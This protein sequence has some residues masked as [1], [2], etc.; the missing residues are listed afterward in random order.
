MILIICENNRTAKTVALAMG[1]KTENATGI[2][3][4][5]TITVATVPV[6][7][8]RQIP[9][10]EMTVEYP[11]I[12]EKF[13]MA[14]TMKQL[15]RKLKP[16][17]HDA[18]EVVFASDGGADAQARFFNICRHFRVG[19]PRS[20]M[21][22]SR[23]SYG[24]IRGAFHFRETGR[25]LHRLAQTGLVSKGMDI[26]FSYNIT[27]ALSNS[28][29]AGFRLSR[30][31][32]MA[33][34]YLA[35][36]TN[37]ANESD[38]PRS[39][40]S[41]QLNVNSQD[42]YE[43]TSIWEDQKEAEAV[44]AD[45]P[46]GSSV[47]GK[48]TITETTAYNLRFHTLLT[49]Q[50]DAYNNLG[51]LPDQT[52]RVA[53]SLY[54]KG[55]I[56]SPMTACS[57]LPANLRGHLETVFGETNGYPWGD[58][59]A[60]LDNHAIIT[61]R[62]TE[63]GMTS[64]EYQLYWLIFNR[65]KAVVEQI[66]TRKYAIIEFTVGNT[67]FSRQWELTGEAYEVTQPGV[68]DTTIKIEDAGVYPCDV[69]TTK[70]NSLSDVLSYLYAKS[71]LVDKT[72]GADIPY[73]RGINDWGSVIGSLVRDGLVS[74]ENGKLNLTEFGGY[75]SEPFAGGEYGETL[76]TWQTEANCI[77]GGDTT[78]RAVIEGFSNSLL[79]MLELIDPSSG[80]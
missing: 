39:G 78:G 57:H 74:L 23:L 2:Y 58:N 52:A 18:T 41:V 47:E 14:V 15:E 64:D 26:L 6:K 30:H 22:L 24:A 40:Y 17:F 76:L 72:I 50:M 69:P 71:E 9:L 38:K 27:R 8:I 67:E 54:T 46:P 55:L 36:I 80:L 77:Y 66:P 51:F 49:L 48:V 13:K 16:L 70:S 32:V 34:E 19:C 65:M 11:F 4:S 25:H 44:L 1:A 79:R 75:A 20:R 3:A 35:E 7:F 29:N 21:W 31:Q 73:S 62:A 10:E 60:T 68:F 53:Y 56:S 42:C 43:S 28:W 37:P 59:G 5:D 63:K 45:I 33:L 12:P 61:L